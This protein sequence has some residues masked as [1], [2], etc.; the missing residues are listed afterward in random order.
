MGVGLDGG[1]VEGR[2]KKHDQNVKITITITKIN[3]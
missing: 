2:E 1:K 3:K